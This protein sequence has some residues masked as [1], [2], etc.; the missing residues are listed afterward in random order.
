MSKFIEYK[1]D[2]GATLLIMA[3][4]EEDQCLI[5]AGKGI[6][7]NI[8]STQNSFSQSLDAVKSSADTLLQKFKNLQADEIE[9]TFG[10]VTTG[11]LGNFA[12]GKVGIEANYEVKLKWKNNQE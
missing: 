11:E 10:L 8:I 7:S 9:M 2:D 5:Q 1:L 4:H 6:Q 12:I 3:V